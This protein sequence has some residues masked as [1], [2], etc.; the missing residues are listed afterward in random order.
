[1]KTNAI[2]AA[3]GSITTPFVFVLST[4]CESMSYFI[5]GSYVQICYNTLVDLEK[6]KK[7]NRKKEKLHPHSE[8]RFPAPSSKL[9]QI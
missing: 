4:L 5:N 7:K 1:M 6:K 8:H 9:C 3:L 2:R